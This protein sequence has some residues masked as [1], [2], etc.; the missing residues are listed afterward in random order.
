[1]KKQIVINKG[2]SEVRIA[3]LEDNDLVELMVERPND[4]KI[5][6]S[7]YKGKI[8]KILHPIKGLFI[9]IGMGQDAFLH[10]N[11]VSYGANFNAYN[12]DYPPNVDKK[13][14][15]KGGEI[16]KG[17]S[18]YHGQKII[19]QAIKEPIGNKGVRV[20][21]EVTLPGRYLV[22]IPGVEAINVSRKI[23]Q[24]KEKK[25]LKNL[26][27]SLLPPN[28][29]V[30]VRT[31]AEAQD[32]EILKKDLQDLLDTWGKI[33][34][35]IDDEKPI[36][37][38]HEDNEISSSVIRDIFRD[39][40]D[41]V[42][43][44]NKKLYKEILSYVKEISPHLVEKVEHYKSKKPIFE[45]FGVERQILESHSKAV[46]CG[47]GG[48]YVIIEQTEAL[49]SIDVNSGKF[50]SNKNSDINSLK[51]NLLAAKEIAK[52]L[53]LR[54]L[55]GLIVI[56]F[57]D[58]LDRK[59]RDALYEG[60]KNELSRDRAK[61][62]MSE[63]SRFGLIELA[64][65]RER[66]SLFHSMS[67]ICPL[68]I[69][70]GRVPT[71]ESI[72]TQIEIWLATFKEHSS[73]KSLKLIVNQSTKDFLTAGLKSVRLQLMFKF[74]LRIDIEVNDKLYDSQFKFFSKKTNQDLTAKYGQTFL[75]EHHQ[76]YA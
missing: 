73:E 63:I 76:D 70:K 42:V 27:S 19:V 14:K 59:N 26:L 58:M 68:C 29:G 38:I 2:L 62:S 21:S 34:S 31:E 20:T 33:Q 61:W 11:D 53:R 72:L 8:V 32:E 9:D 74:F 52:Q 49:V 60:F 4:E 5:I 3:I 18:L 55:G 30:I 51:V 10:F 1:M 17:L 75:P 15:G 12:D 41:R 16:R 48:V 43:I 35:R 65:Q 6:G 54:D 23:H 13:L 25:R 40:I 69:G 46:N 56:D 71:K 64:R 36:D 7:I 67:D 57:I 45:D 47:N 39:N 66:E 44:D 37:I 28:F 22:L 24:F 50:L